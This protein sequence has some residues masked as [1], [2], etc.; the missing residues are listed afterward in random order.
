EKGDGLFGGEMG[1]EVKGEQNVDS[2]RRPELIDTGQREEKPGL[3]IG[4]LDRPGA[5]VKAPRLFSGFA[6]DVD[7]VAAG[8]AGIDKRSGIGKEIT[9]P[10]GGVAEHDADRLRRIPRTPIALAA[11]VKVVGIVP[12]PGDGDG[13]WGRGGNKRHG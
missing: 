1:K 2:L 4:C 8:A 13:R 5:M 10:G 3:G 12:V 9:K 7:E 6:Q 11:V